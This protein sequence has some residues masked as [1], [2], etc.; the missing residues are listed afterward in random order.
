M[1]KENQ[2][3]VKTILTEAKEQNI[4]HKAKIENEAALSLMSAF[5][6]RTCIDLGLED[7]LAIIEEIEEGKV[8]NLLIKY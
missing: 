6:Y 1:Y 5:N 8:K 2:E 7:A 3:K 4:R